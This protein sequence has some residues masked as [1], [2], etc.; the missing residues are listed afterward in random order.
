MKI[1]SRSQIQKQAEVLGLNSEPK[2]DLF[3]LMYKNNVYVN[4]INEWLVVILIN[5]Q[6]S[7]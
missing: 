5:M 6:R 1:N 3:Y 7:K 2:A 4:K